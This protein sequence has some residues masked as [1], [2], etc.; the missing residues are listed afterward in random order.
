MQE[1]LKKKA[2]M[3]RRKSRRS[4]RNSSE[5]SEESCS[6]ND[7]NEVD[8]TELVTESL[9]DDEYQIRN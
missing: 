2:D 7:T 3:E 9:D 8:D 6:G 1:K 4:Q 5:D